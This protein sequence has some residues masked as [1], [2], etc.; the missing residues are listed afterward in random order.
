MGIYEIKPKDFNESA[1]KL[2]GSDWMLV[3]AA[4]G[5]DVNTMTASWGTFGIMWNK[6]VVSIVL[7]PQR[8]T[9]EFVDSSDSFS[10]T[11]FDKKYKK[12]LSYLG[13]VSGRDEKNKIDKTNLTV[14]FID[15]VPSFEEAKITIIAKK[16]F[17]QNFTPDSFIDETILDKCYPDKDYH[18]M[19]FAEIE[20]ILISN[21]N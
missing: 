7:R 9:K 21:D 5:E 20:K 10:L 12:D 15:G 8:Y 4:K 17:A 2:I 19:Y 1:F 11:I 6:N 18:T 16:L 13:T 3:T 14:K